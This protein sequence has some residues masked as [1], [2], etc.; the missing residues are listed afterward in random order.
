MEAKYTP[1]TTAVCTQDQGSLRKTAAV[2]TQDQGNLRKTASLHSR[3]RHVYG[4]PRQFAHKTKAV[5]GRQQQRSRQSTEDY[6]TQDTESHSSLYTE[7]P[8]EGHR[9]HSSLWKATLF[10]TED[11]ISLLEDQSSLH[12]GPQRSAHNGHSNI[13]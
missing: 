11:H 1:E 9:H 2:Y 3:S 10:C 5:Y 8:T 12:T 4:K 13:Q 6:G 7:Q